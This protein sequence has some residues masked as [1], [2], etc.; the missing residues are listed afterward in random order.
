MSIHSV[1]MDVAINSTIQHLLGDDHGQCDENLFGMGERVR[2]N[3]TEN[4]DSNHLSDSSDDESIEAAVCPTCRK[5][6]KSA[7]ILA[8]EHITRCQKALKASGKGHFLRDHMSASTN[9]EDY[10]LPSIWCWH[11]QRLVGANKKP[12]KCWDKDCDG[13]KGINSVDKDPVS[14]LAK[15]TYILS[16][17]K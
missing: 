12:L 13:H 5:T 8:K 15:N 2:N 10:L 7:N 17:P 1:K 11:P 4:I 9:L 14:Q 3:Q 6:C 16:I